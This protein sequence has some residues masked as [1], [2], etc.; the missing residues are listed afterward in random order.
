LLSENTRIGKV[1]K[2]KT[3]KSIFYCMA[4]LL[5][6]CLPSLHPLYNEKT[7]IFK[8]E[9]IGKWMGD[10]GGLWQ[11]TKA[12]EKEYELRIRD[13]QEEI[14]R[15]SAHLIELEG[16]MFLDLYPDSKPL[17]DMDDFYKIHILP[18][19]TFMKVDRINPNLQ[20]R[21]VDYEKVENMLEN[22]PN[23]IKHE[24]AD[25]RI[26]LTASTEEIQD[27]VVKHVE[28][29]FT[30]A[31][32]DSSGAI[33]L[34]PLYSEENIVIDP[35]FVGQ[36]KDEDDGIL[37][38]KK[39]GEKTYELKYVGI[40]GTEHKVFA[41]LLR[42]GNELLM[43]VFADKAE[44]DPHQPYSYAFHL[45]PDWFLRVEKTE[46]ELKLQKL[47]YEE[48]SQIL[49]NNTSPVKSQSTD[50]SY[51]FKGTRIEL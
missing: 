33:R 32:D 43:A 37:Y 8:E 18:V 9:L 17:E 51:L 28:T 13:D 11:F 46:P 23:L 49:R 35:N 22:D 42:H 4:L 1:L 48:A 20:L 10:D 24:I 34:E 7:L 39:M 19:H 38:S 47:N 45:I 3:K 44:L 14:G 5:T 26:V 12:G 16:M 40:D 50:A 36:W 29:I 6:G 21:M 2:M 30:D 25:D 31:S 15:F 27:F 41:N